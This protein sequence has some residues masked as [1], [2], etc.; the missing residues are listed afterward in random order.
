M[1]TK[2]EAFDVSMSVPCNTPPSYNAIFTSVSA[3]SIWSK[4]W[5]FSLLQSKQ[6]CLSHI[7]AIVSSPDFTPS[8]IAQTVSACVTTLPAAEFSK[9]LQQPNIEGH[10]ALYWAIVNDRREALLAFINFIP[11]LSPACSSDLRLAC[12]MVSDHALFTWLDLG[13]KLNHKCV[14]LPPLAAL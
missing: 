5:V 8:S 14:V 9:L 11:K 3:D 2:S 10:T 12:M 13:K 6:N 7:C 1:T 4:L